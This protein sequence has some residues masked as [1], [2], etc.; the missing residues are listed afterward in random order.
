MRVVD[1]RNYATPWPNLNVFPTHKAF[2]FGY[3]F[4]SLT[5]TKNQSVLLKVNML[6]N[7]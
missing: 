6:I 3:I 2:L 1:G 5:L 7:L 4:S